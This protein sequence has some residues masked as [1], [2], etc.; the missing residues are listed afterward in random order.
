MW[1]VNQ[2]SPSS[3]PQIHV[4]LYIERPE[5][6]DGGCGGGN[7][8]DA[9]NNQSQCTFM[10]LTSYER[11]NERI[12]RLRVQTERIAKTLQLGRLLQERL[13]QSISSGMEVLLDR[14]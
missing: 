7:G 11:F 4:V 10:N 13:F 9:Q 2:K 5:A 14:I 12:R 1:V 3:H 8:A 6:G